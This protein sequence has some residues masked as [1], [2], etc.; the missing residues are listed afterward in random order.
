[1]RFSR[2]TLYTFVFIETVNGQLLDSIAVVTLCGKTRAINEKHRSASPAIRDRFRR[3][4]V[5][6]GTPLLL[7]GKQTRPL[8]RVVTEHN[9]TEN[10]QECLLQ[11]LIDQQPNVLPIC[12]FYAGATSAFSLGREIPVA[13]GASD[14]FVDNMLVTDDGHLVV[15]ETKL[16]RNPEATREVIAQILQYG[17][18][19]SQLPFLEFEARLRKADSR[20]RR[21]A[22]DETV[23][24]YVQN[25]AASESLRGLD[26]DFEDAF[27]RQRR[28]GEILLLIVADRIRVSAERLVGWMNSTFGHAP[29]KLGIVDLRL[30]DLADVGRIIIPKTLLRTR[31]ASRHVVSINLQGAARDQVTVAVTGPNGQP[32]IR[33]PEPPPLPMTE[34]RL[35][36]LI[37]ARNSREAAE[38]AEELRAQLES[39]GLATRSLTSVIQYGVRVYDDFVPL[40]HLQP[41]NIYFQIPMRAV[42]DLGDDA[43]V[44]IK[45]KINAVATFY[46]PLDIGDPTKTNTLGPNY[47]VLMGKIE[48]F[49]NAVTEIAAEVK[50]AMEEES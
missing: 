47:K 3:P 33:K 46:R 39:S 34:E 41:V 2:P 30:Y 40:L 24:K 4:N 5:T 8:S 29:H 15:V 23:T 28:A 31:E 19:V 37:W 27:D 18:A 45:R 17:M 22:P 49:V 16:W 9:G 1:M 11:E 36:E 35:T 26:D 21:L 10:I 38:V 48:A 6:P 13:I 14:G 20:G 44:G 12:D 7:S 42:R 25:L 43:F 32:E 50:N